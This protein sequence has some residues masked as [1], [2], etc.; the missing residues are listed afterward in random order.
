MKKIELSEM[1][2]I[3]DEIYDVINLDCPLKVRVEISAK[4]DTLSKMCERLYVT[5]NGGT[6][7]ACQDLCKISPEEMMATSEYTKMLNLRKGEVLE[8]ECDKNHYKYLRALIKKTN[9]HYRIRTINLAGNL[10]RMM[11][12]DN[13]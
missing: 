5:N 11:R 2:E 3:I 4:L 12:I 8:I 10:R 13:G 1:M 6:I 7:R 9:P